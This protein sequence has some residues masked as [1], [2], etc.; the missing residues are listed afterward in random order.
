M[1]VEGVDD[2]RKPASLLACAVLILMG[3]SKPESPP[4]A[5]DAAASS[6]TKVPAMP[7]AAFPNQLLWGDQHVHTSYSGDA[8]AAGTIVTPERTL[9]F[10]RGETVKSN[11]GQDAKL[12]RPLDW[13]V[14]SDH[15][16][17]LGVISE[18]QEGNTEMMADSTV[19][20]W[21]DLMAKGGDSAFQA[22]REMIKAQASK[23]LPKIMMDPKWAVS[24][25]QKSVDTMEKYNEPGKFTAFIGFEWTS[26][27]EVGQ[28]LHRNVVFREGP[29]KTRD[30]PPLTTFVSAAPGRAGTDPES[31][32]KWLS[33]WETK[34]GGHALAIPHNGDMSNGWMFR[35]ARYDGSPLTPE[36][37]AARA[38]WEVLLE[39]FQYKG[40]GETHPALSPG[41]EFANFEI[42]DTSDLAGNP[43]PK[44]AIEFEYAR[45][46]LLRG[47]RLQ[48]Q[49]GTNPFKIGMV[50][51]TDTH[52]GL[53]S[54]GEENNW[55][56]KFPASEPNAKRW[57]GIYKKEAK[58]VRKDWTLGAAGVTGV[59]S[60]ANTRGAIWDAMKRREV[61]ASSGPRIK[62]RLFAG[63]DFT[64]A[65]ADGDVAAAG[66]ARG[67]PMGGD[68]SSGEAGRSPTLLLAAMK[69]PDGAN[70]DRVQV[71]KGWIDGAGKPQEKVYDVLW[72]DGLRH[73]AADGKLPAVGNTVDLA[74]ATYTNGIGA[75]ELKG[76]FKDPNFDRSQRAFYYARVIEIPTPRWTAYD[77]VKYQVKM[78]AEVPMIIQERAVTSPVWYEPPK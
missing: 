72:S 41:D 38:R 2:M 54:G 75:P 24:V 7:P 29:E 35:E 6:P 55:W 21:H 4:P 56:G 52:T 1:P 19:K 59:W 63:W 9:R 43:K 74:T 42:W 78:D 47:M 3:C 69:D 10:A 76:I 60:T 48:D 50:S 34:T 57:G 53:P 15:S 27:G 62:V 64:D 37:A 40:Q 16:D 20:R 65:D 67:V 66:Y 17:G 45:Q 39:I 22:A 28:N 14:I 8:A 26:N 23:S 30:T 70:L 46:A 49:L 44:G 5:V 31:L 36:W 61:Y 11:T 13:I 33:D 51:G 71:I 25:W 77:S 18:V 58:Y 12:H 32:W 73:P 68:L